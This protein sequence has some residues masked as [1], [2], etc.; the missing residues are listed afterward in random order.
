MPA[1]TPITLR[2]ALDLI[3]RVFSGEAMPDDALLLRHLADCVDGGTRPD[4]RDFT[5]DCPQDDG[6]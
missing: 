1:P 6:E 4:D 3:L 2:D 5:L